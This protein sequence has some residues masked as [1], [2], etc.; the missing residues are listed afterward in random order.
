MF[1]LWE[2][3]F[4]LFLLFFAGDIEL[5]GVEYVLPNDIKSWCKCCYG[6]EIGRTNPNG[7]DC[8]FL[9]E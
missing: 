3:M 1:N 8:V 5:S 7:K 4:L 2:F 9:S 6:I